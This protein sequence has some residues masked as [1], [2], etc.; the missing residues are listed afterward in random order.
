T[1]ANDTLKPIHHRMPVVID[2]PDFDVWL[3]TDETRASDAAPLLRPAANDY[4]I[5]EPA[6]MERPRKPAAP[7][8]AQPQ[9]QSSPDQLKLF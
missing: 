2:P 3:D 1:A 6:V 9:P 8:P 7:S 4:F 5:A